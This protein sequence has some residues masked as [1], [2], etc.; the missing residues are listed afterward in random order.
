MKEGGSCEMMMH[1]SRASSVF[2]K[3]GPRNIELL[4]IGGQKIYLICRKGERMRG[5]S[6]VTRKPNDR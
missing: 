1:T 4:K 2:E 6:V 3:I 5:L